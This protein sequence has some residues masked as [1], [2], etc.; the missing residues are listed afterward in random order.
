MSQATFVTALLDRDKPVPDGLRTWNGSDPL[1]RFRVY[2]N[3]VAVALIDTLAATFPVTLALC[4]EEFFRAMTRAFALGSPPA[5]PL[6]ADFGQDLP[7]FIAGYAAAQKVPYLA[8]VARLEAARALV[9]HAGD[10]A[11]LAAETFACWQDRI[12]EAVLT[13]HPAH[14]VLV[15]PYP[16][17][18]IWAAHNGL[19]DLEDIDLSQPEEALVVRPN[20][21]TEI[22][23]LPPGGAAFVRALEAGQS[24]ADAAMNTLADTPAFEPAMALS[25]VIRARLV[26]AIHSGACQ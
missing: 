10:A 18:S 5:S 13:V 8:D 4:G 24:V 15:S 19:G 7:D 3:N 22:W 2:R 20:L 14:A 16:V 11:P 23:R 26:T 6:L 12:G 17:V 25:L 21:E 1:Q 9:W